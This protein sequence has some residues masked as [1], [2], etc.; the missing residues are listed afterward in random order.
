[1]QARKLNVKQWYFN[2]DC[3]MYMLDGGKVI[4]SDPHKESYGNV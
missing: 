2:N 1:M 4:E 3:K